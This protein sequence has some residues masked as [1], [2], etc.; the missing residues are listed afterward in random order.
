MSQVSEFWRLHTWASEVNWENHQRI[1]LGK[2][3]L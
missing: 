1:Q 2:K 3:E